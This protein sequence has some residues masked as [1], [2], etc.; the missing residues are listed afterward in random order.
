MPLS[1][2]CDACGL[3]TSEPRRGLCASCW[4][5]APVPIPLHGACA[6]CR[7]RRRDLL[8]W[9]LLARVRVL[10]CASCGYVAE[11]ARPRPSDIAALRALV[12]SD[13]RR[14]RGDRRRAPDARAPE[15]RGGARR[16]P[17]HVARG[18]LP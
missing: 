14:R 8:R 17:D 18:P 4:S 3:P 16:H 6:A 15:R 13:R 1:R 7:E 10:T 2:S 11:A 12:A 9:T 5:T